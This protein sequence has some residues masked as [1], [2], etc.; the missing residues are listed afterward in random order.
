[1]GEVTRTNQDLEVLDDMVRLIEAAANRDPE[2]AHAAE[3]EIYIRVL[4][5]IRDGSPFPR[6]LAARALR[7]RDLDFPRWFA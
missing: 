5:M 7:L 3:D 6:E 4:E 1:M 2:S